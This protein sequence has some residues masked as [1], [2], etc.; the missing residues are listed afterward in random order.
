[1]RTLLCLLCVVLAC[2]TL[3]A[4]AQ[5]AGQRSLDVPYVPTPP[6]VV[7][8]MLKLAQ[9]TKD[10]YV[11]DLGSGDGRIV[12]AAAQKFGAHGMGID[13]NPERIAEA[14]EN[15]KKAGV[16][17]L[18]EFKEGD[19]FKADLSK[20]T[21][22]TMYLLTSVNMRIRDKLLTELKPGTRLVSHAF[23]MGE[24]KPEKTSEVGYRRVYYWTV[25]A[26]KPQFKDTPAAQ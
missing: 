1:M 4:A 10:D 21:V 15:A 9:V 14:R 25:P 7:D 20:A 23:D 5:E 11:I 16:T 6:E 13:L 26:S 3:P 19:L 22:I 18:V 24:W 8:E 2:I 12:I 17:D